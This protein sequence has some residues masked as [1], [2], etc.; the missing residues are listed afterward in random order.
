MLCLLA[1]LEYEAKRI[2]DWRV[3]GGGGGLRAR[4]GFAAITGPRFPDYIQQRMRGIAVNSCPQ[5]RLK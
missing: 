3:G 4:R 5:S 2:S 1:E